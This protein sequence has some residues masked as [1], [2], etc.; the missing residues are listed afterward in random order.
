MARS[1]H[2]CVAQRRLI[3]KVSAVVLAGGRSSRFGRDKSLLRIDDEL[4]V[5]RSLRRWGHMFDEIIIVSDSGCKFDIA[6]ITEVRD[7]YP[8]RGPLGGVHAGLTAVRNQWAFV[9][10]CDMPSIEN[11]FIQRLFDAVSDGD[12]VILPYHNGMI[13]PLCALYHTDCLPFAEDMLSRESNCILDMYEMVPVL[14]FETE[15]CFFNINY[16]EDADSVGTAKENSSRRYKRRLR[17]FC[18]EKGL[19]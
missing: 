7:I 5:E 19:S 1:V 3:L 9:V 16:P 2:D 6:G 13:E 17:I 4:L 11:D 8:R 12:R 18:G 10:A 14:Y 15:N